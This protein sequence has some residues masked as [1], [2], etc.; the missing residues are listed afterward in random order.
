MRL[1]VKLLVVSLICLVGVGFYLG[2]F[3]LTNSTPDAEGGKMNI[4]VS[5]DKD[6]AKSDFKKA[7]EK[8]KELKGKG[9]ATEAK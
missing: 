8:I 1:L 6:K 7:T 9:K 2:W 5:V 4:N 3:S